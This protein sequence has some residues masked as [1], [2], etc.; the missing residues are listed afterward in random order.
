M[1]CFPVPILFDCAQLPSGIAHVLQHMR[2]ILYEFHPVPCSK[3]F[4]PSTAL[5]MLLTAPITLLF[6]WRAND[7]QHD[8]MAECCNCSCGIIMMSELKNLI[9]HLAR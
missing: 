6:K 4:L 1:H 9:E 3:Q 5:K 7:M 2:V 8:L